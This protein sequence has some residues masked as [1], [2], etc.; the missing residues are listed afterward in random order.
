MYG[1]DGDF[2]CLRELSE[3]VSREPSRCRRNEDNIKM[4]LKHKRCADADCIKMVYKM[5]HWHPFV[6]RMINLPRP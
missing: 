5:F 4:E 2:I 1:G 6:G 3:N